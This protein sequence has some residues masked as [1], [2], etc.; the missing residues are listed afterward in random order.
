MKWSVN[1]CNWSVFSACSIMVLTCSKSVWHECLQSWFSA[2][3]YP[4]CYNVPSLK[5]HQAT[6][7]AVFRFIYQLFSHFDVKWLVAG[8]T[9]ALGSPWCFFARL[10]HLQLHDSALMSDET[11]TE[12]NRN[13]VCFLV[14]SSQMI[15][16]G[17]FSVVCK[18]MYWCEFTMLL[19]VKKKSAP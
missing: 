12:W 13:R 4:P 10:K 19:L 3:A 14:S 11:K 8:W 1:L 18:H 5:A 9:K 15:I 7:Y 2:G 17:F 6:R 16:A